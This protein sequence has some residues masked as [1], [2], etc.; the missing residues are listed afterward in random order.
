[1]HKM[2]KKGQIFL[3]GFVVIYGLILSS[4]LFTVISS[5]SN[6]ED[7]IGLRA[8]NLIKT[9]QESEKMF[10]YLNLATKYSSENTIREIGENG[11]YSENNRCE[12]TNPTLI[13]KNNYVIWN[14][15][16]VLDPTAEFIE[17][18]KKEILDYIKLYES[19]Y[20]KTDFEESFDIEKNY[21]RLEGVSDEIKDDYNYIYT[22][23]FRNTN[24]LNIQ[25]SNDK[26]IINFSDILLPIEND[27]PSF[28]TIKPTTQLNIPELTIYKKLYLLISNNCIKKNYEECERTIKKDFTNAII[29]KEDN[30][31]KL[32]I[33]YNN[34]EIRYA[35][36]LDKPIPPMLFI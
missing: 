9:E 31:V 36:L 12:K 4:L 8:M 20:R 34:Y 22:K 11:G 24:I 2:N 19:T 27:Q 7:L 29:F 10:L 13:D 32:K 26:I 3:M 6:K 35:F 14:T 30:L 23:N 18:L 5:A 16:P 33:P 21:P 17:Q 28:T 1:M 25:I 15:C